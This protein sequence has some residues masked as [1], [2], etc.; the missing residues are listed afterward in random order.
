[1]GNQNFAQE[2]TD[3]SGSSFTDRISAILPLIAGNVLEAEER[4]SLPPENIGWLREAGVFR[5]LVPAAY[6]GDEV[7]LWDFLQG[8]RLLSSAC[9]SSGWIAGVLGTHAHGIAY[10]AKAAQDEVWADG[11]DTLICS[12]FAPVVTA[13]KVE[14]GYRLSGSWDFSSGSDHASWV[15]LGF[16]VA[17]APDDTSYLGLIPRTEF[18]VVDNWSTVG[19][20]GTGSNRVTVTDIFVPEYRCWGPGLFAAPVEP[21][22]HGSWLFKIPFV[23]TATNFAAVVLGAADGAI[24]A[25]RESVEKRI[26]PH[27]GKP[28]IENPLAYI[29]LAESALDLRAATALLEQRWSA[30]IEQ[31]KSG[32]Q[33]SLDEATL[34]RGD[35]AYAGR[36]CV[37]AVDRLMNAGGGSAAFQAR[38]LQRY[39]R[40]IH[41]AGNH[42]F[43]DLENRLVI[44]GRHLM[45]LPPEPHLI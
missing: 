38:P 18:S 10:Y 15:Q 12:S 31:A 37:Q 28:R 2:T 29:R 42:M 21:A 19:M 1:M 30:I 6:G 27:T 20:R 7:D 32:Q 39:W 4:R 24:A 26:R 34:V 43:F 33:Q 41:T 16:R 45:G 40:D 44:V 13:Q 11:P 22:L 9:V 3:K 8:V 35:E 23:A 5:A 25:Y 14:G 17:G 36:L